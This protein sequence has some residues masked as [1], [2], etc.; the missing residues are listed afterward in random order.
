MEY[1]DEYIEKIEETKISTSELYNVSSI[2]TEIDDMEEYSTY[3]WIKILY[4]E[5]GQIT[6]LKY[7]LEFGN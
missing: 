7:S 6:I 4:K 5:N 1:A 3:G 2:N